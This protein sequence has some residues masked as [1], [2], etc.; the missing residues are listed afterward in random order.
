MSHHVWKEYTYCLR[1]CGI[2]F[3]HRSGSE[4][5]RLGS[6]LFSLRLL[7]RY[8]SGRQG[9]GVRGLLLKYRRHRLSGR[10]LLAGWG[11]R[12]DQHPVELILLGAWLR[13]R[14]GKKTETRFLVIAFLLRR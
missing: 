2:V 7:R 4:T 5:G 10:L 12:V 3:S 1:I 9:C 8:H 6:W 14:Y 11:D 13:Q